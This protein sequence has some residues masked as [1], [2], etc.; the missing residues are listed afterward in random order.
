M[1]VLQRHVDIAHDLFT[2]RDG[3]DQFIRPMRRMRVE[4][5]N[6]EI[7]GNVVQLAQE[8]AQSLRFGGQCARGGLESVR[9]GN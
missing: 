5:T 1:N 8:A 9:R 4:D 2:F 3:A 7:A 6:P